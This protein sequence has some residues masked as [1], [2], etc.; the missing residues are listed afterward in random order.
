MFDGR[1]RAGGLG[2]AAREFFGEVFSPARARDRIQARETV[3]GQGAQ[4]YAS[5]GMQ[6]RS[7]RAR[8]QG[9]DVDR[10]RA[11]AELVAAV[12]AG[13][14]GAEERLVARLLPRIKRACQALLRGSADADDAMQ[15]ALMRV[16]E[17]LPSFRAEASLDRWARRVTVNVCLRQLERRRRYR[18]PLEDDADLEGVASPA[19]APERLAE[20]LPRRVWDYLDHLSEEQRQAIVLRHVYEYSVAEIAELVA[21]RVDTVK[22]R[23]LYGRRR[24]RKLVRRDVAL[25]AGGGTR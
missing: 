11:D 4:V 20:A 18:R 5:A 3:R 17:N 8:P 25:G 1:A 14:A 9:A 15:V 19:P 16:L 24:L 23:L 7:A 6:D 12:L 2:G 22:S 13:D 21:A 10:R